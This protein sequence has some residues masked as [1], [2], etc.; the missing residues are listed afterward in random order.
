MTIYI[1]VVLVFLGLCLGSFLGAQVWRLRAH[2]L[3]EEKEAGESYDKAEYKRLKLLLKQSVSDDRSHCLSCGHQLGGR[4]LIPLMSWLGTKGRCRYCKGKIGRFEPAIE[5]GTM[6]FFVVSYLAWPVPLESFSLDLLGF[7][8]WL[9]VGLMLIALFA[10]D[11]KWFLLPDKLMFP[12]MVLAAIVAEIHIVQSSDAAQAILSLNGA[13]AVL[14]GLYLAIYV[15]GGLRGRQWIGF[16]DVKLGLVL[17]LV[18]ADWK[19]ALLTLFLANFIGCLIILPLMAMGK[20]SRATR[21]PF[22]PMLIAGFFIT[23][24]FG[25]GIVDWYLSLTMFA[26]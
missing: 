8:L 5:L 16:G 10:Y 1:L 9:I 19:L 6:L 26:I 18:L 13:I 7:I 23:A 3:A 20:I 12:A 25:Q 2:Q 15:V 4:D 22:G 24:L 11:L 17:A 14:S 21:V